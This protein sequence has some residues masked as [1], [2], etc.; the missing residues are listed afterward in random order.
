MDKTITIALNSYIDGNNRVQPKIPD[1]QEYRNTRV[2][3]SYDINTNPIRHKVFLKSLSVLHLEFIK[4]GIHD[5]SNVS[6]NSI[7]LTEQ[8]YLENS[9]TAVCAC[10]YEHNKN[11]CSAVFSMVDF[12]HDN[13]YVLM[14]YKDNNS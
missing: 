5:Y 14:K 12:L 10:S 2:T 8:T 3:G 4:Q 9:I 6:F 13:T 11:C 1:C 7:N